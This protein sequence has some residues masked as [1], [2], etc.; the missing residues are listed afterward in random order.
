MFIFNSKLYST[1]SLPILSNDTGFKYLSCTFFQISFVFS[2]IYIHKEFEKLCC[3]HTYH[4]E[5]TMNVS[6]YLFYHISIHLLILISI[7]QLPHEH[8]KHLKTFY[9]KINLGRISFYFFFFQL[10]MSYILNHYHG[11][12][13]NNEH[14]LNTP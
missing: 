3:E 13:D 8:F 14:L 9:R 7:H 12:C 2:N 6:V 10:F 1:G 11:S 5:T 4:L